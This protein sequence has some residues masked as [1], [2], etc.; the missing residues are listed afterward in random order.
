VSLRPSC[1]PYNEL[2]SA[3][4]CFSNL[5]LFLFQPNFSEWPTLLLT[6]NRRSFRA[7]M[8]F[9][10]G[11]TGYLDRNRAQRIPSWPGERNSPTKAEYICADQLAYFTFRLQKS[12]GPYICSGAYSLLCL[13]VRGESMSF[14]GTKYY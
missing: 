10:R 1:D 9:W 6:V 5:H 14:H 13:P 2:S 8:E 7:R 4:N 3:R 12:G 11:T